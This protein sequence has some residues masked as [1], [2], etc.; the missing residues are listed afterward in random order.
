MIMLC[1]GSTGIFFIVE[2]KSHSGTITAS[3][4]GKLLRNGKPL[5]KDVVKQVWQQVSWLKKTLESRMGESVF[6]PSIVGGRQR[7]CAGSQPGQRG[8]C[9][10]RANGWSKRSQQEKQA[11]GPKIRHE[12]VGPWGLVFPHPSEGNVTGGCRSY[13]GV[14]SCWGSR[15]VKSAGGTDVRCAAVGGALRRLQVFSRSPFGKKKNQ[16]PNV[17]YNLQ[18][19]C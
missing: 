17:K 11:R 4:D 8:D 13:P 15:V 14:S 16:M 1:R 6:I 5:E 7:V 2:T 19:V 18:Y 3:A 12:S 9:L 10:Y